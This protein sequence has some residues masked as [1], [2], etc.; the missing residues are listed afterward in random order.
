MK[1]DG[2]TVSGK[3]PVGDGPQGCP[4]C[5]SSRIRPFARAHGRR[6]RECPDCGLVHLAPEQRLDRAAEKRRYDLHENSP[7]D[8]GYRAFLDR[9]AAP[10]VER[11]EPGAE[12]LDYGSGP[13]PTLSV[14]LEEQGFPMAIYDPFYAPDPGPL[15]RRYDFV[16]CTETVEHFFDP[17]AELAHLRRLVR[18]GG[19]LAI[20]TEVLGPE[21]DFE[22]WHF[23]R[24]PTHVCLY[25]R[26]TMDWIADRLGWRLESP[27]SSVFLLRKPAHDGR[28]NRAPDP[29]C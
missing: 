7:D 22:A 1:G 4:L 24:D 8:P 9:L 18:P 20:M 5:G 19:W 17:G 12:G 23:A 16:T 6:Y 11:L 27:R 13:G 21:Q 26:R 28:G 29:S 2:V 25:R 10:L 15:R 3:G 14:M